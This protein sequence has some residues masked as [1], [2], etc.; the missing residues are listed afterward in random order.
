MILNH[1]VFISQ[2][3]EVTTC[4]KE[5]QHNLWCTMKKNKS[6]EVPIAYRPDSDVK[7]F[8]ESYCPSNGKLPAT[9][10]VDIAVRFL[11]MHP[12]TQVDSIVM[13][14]LKG[15]LRGYDSPEAKEFEDVIRTKKTGT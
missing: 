1:F 8:I 13:G 15:R 5:R 14:I 7:K 9:Q 2:R 3:L 10:L 6:T 4:N 12:E 11:M